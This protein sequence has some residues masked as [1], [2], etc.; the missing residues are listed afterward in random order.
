M[1]LLQ[2]YENNQLSLLNMTSP[3]LLAT[4]RLGPLIMTDLLKILE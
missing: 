2:N 3:H 1:K 4:C